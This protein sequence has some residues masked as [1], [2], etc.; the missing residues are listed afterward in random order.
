M[1]FVTLGTQK[2]QMER[3][4]K[5]ADEVA[6]HVDEEVF[7]QTGH[8][9]YKPRNCSY[10][11]FLRPEEY[12]ERIENCSVLVTHAGVGTIITGLNAHKPVIVVPRLAGMH[13]H[14]DDHQIQIAE[15]FS[16][17]NCVIYCKDTKDLISDIARAR[18]HKFEEYKVRGGNI[19]DLILNFICLF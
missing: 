1:I 8:T 2:F 4:V 18:D 17:K 9:E 7:I 13:E 15:A 12:K 10:K 3:L 6:E 19:E 14:V 11:D 5:A 16:T